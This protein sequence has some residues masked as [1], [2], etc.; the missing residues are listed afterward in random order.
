MK[1]LLLAERL[2]PQFPVLHQ[3]IRNRPLV[4]FDNASTTQKPQSVIDKE[5]A[6][7]INDNANVHRTPHD[8]AGRATLAYEAVREKTKQF[9]NATSEREIIFTK[10]TTE[11]IN[12]IAQSYGSLVVKT[13]DE[14][15]LTEMEHHSNI[16]PWQLLAE[17][18][19]AKV[20]V[21]PIEKNGDLNLEKFRE[22]LSLRT[23][24]VSCTHVSNALGTVNPLHRIIP[25]V[26]QYAPQ[27]AIVIDGAQWIAHSPTDVKA[28]DADFYVFS[29]HKLFGPTGVGVLYG[30]Q[31]ILERMPPFIGGGDMIERVS[32]QKSTYASIPSRFEAGTPNIAGVIGFGA[33]LDFM[34]SL[35]FEEI[36]A[37]EKIFSE[38]VLETLKAVPEVKLIGSPKERLSVASF[39]IQGIPSIDTAVLFN[40]HGI[41][42]RAGHH[43][44]M[45]LMERL[46]IEGT[47]R[48]SWSLYNTKEDIDAFGLALQDIAGKRS[49]KMISRLSPQQLAHTPIEFRTPLFPTLSEAV[50]TV[51]SHFDV[52]DDNALK[53]EVLFELGQ[54]HPN[55]LS[56]L[57]EH[58]PPVQGCM[59]EVRVAIK[60]K[61]GRLFI[62]SDSNAA[63]IRGLL[64]IVELIYSGHTIEEAKEFNIYKFFEDIS[65]NAFLSVQRRSGLT[66][67]LKIIEEKIAE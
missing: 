52:G 46:G 20:V 26:R 59:S 55:I 29:S 12:I 19:G 47:I 6:F 43:C 17:R 2:R 38:Y 49:K 61:D 39:S 41:A 50:Q 4:Y 32:F 34:Q 65:L 45:P 44:C 10:G 54:D 21:A 56:M 31:E 51:R 9:L 27:A 35:R 8:L 57:R 7:Y 24:I 5:C 30:K 3:K 15:L 18:S 36:V 63:V 11:G 13:N 48:A 58:T 1:T 22:R 37:E 25:M 42:L 53:Q 14:I 16:V 67:V 28:L 62:A 23:K 60:K 66:G 64:S 33:A 40:Q